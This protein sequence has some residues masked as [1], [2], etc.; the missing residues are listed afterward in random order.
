M[1]GILR[2]AAVKHQVTCDDFEAAVLD[3][4]RTYGKVIDDPQN[5]AAPDGA[6]L[7]RLERARD[8]DAL[9]TLTRA[10]VQLVAQGTLGRASSDTEIAVF[11]FN[12]LE[13][14]GVRRPQNCPNLSSESETLGQS[15]RRLR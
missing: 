3:E 1:H 11:S 14:K 10:D 4:Y 6:P 2:Q 13:R 7:F 15:C 12:C 9:Y 5:I 8:D